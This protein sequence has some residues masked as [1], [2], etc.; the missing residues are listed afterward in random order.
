MEKFTIGEI[1]QQL[2]G[3]E[4]VNNEFL[5]AL[6]K[7]S[8]KGVQKLVLKWER[9]EE[10]KKQVHEQFVNMTSF[11][12]KY[13]S[14]GFRYIAG[15]DEAGRGPLA[16]P[17]VAGAVILPENFYLPGLNDSKKLTESKRDEYFEVIMSEALAVGVGL[18]SAAEI[19]EINI[20]QASKKAMLSAVNQ[21]GITPDFLLIDAVKLDT[22]YPFEALIKGDSR[23]ISIAAASII[24]KVTRDRLM[25]ELSIEFPPY[26]FGANM[27]Y[28]TAEHL[29]AIKEHGVTDHHR[30]TF[31]P[32][33]E[34]IQ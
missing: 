26:G 3:K 34:Y 31:A 11:E 21:L 24:A 2:F 5:K 13:R 16:G 23:S 10:Q 32:V 20:L 9:Q 1:E 12:R 14:E 33:R 4:E 6:K 15:I 7:D 28:G 18:I 27:G 19:D 17:V 25:K 8:R 29:R 22:P 30:K